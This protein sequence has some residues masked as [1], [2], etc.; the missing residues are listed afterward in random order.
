MFH[1]HL[2]TCPFRW[3]EKNIITDLSTKIIAGQLGEN[4]SVSVESDGKKL[5]YNIT[6]LNKDRSMDGVANGNPK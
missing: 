3:M 2:F 4:C 6:N 5:I 1:Y